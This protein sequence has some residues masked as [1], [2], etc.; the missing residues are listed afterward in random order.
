MLP[1]VF[2]VLLIASIAHAVQF[3]EALP[4]I[5]AAWSDQKGCFLKE[6]NKVIPFGSTFPGDNC[7][8][9][10]CN[11]DAIRYTT[12]M[13][14]NLTSPRCKVVDPKKGTYPECCPKPHCD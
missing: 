4:E 5:P 6:H 11:T 1:K 2:F 12:C 9:I 8:L 10:T 7:S 3:L 14:F 13:T